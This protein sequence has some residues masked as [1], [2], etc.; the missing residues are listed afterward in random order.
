LP[1]LE[2]LCL[3]RVRASPTWIQQHLQVARSPRLRELC[4]VELWGPHPSAPPK[5]DKVVSPDFLGQLDVLQANFS[6]V[7]ADSEFEQVLHPP[8]LVFSSRDTG[9]GPLPRHS[10]CHPAHFRD[11]QDLLDS[12]SLLARQLYLTPPVPS[13]TSPPR[14]LI[15]P[16]NLRRSAETLTHV[17]HHLRAIEDHCAEKGVRIVWDEE[18]HDR[19]FVSPALRRY[20]RELREARALE[21]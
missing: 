3:R 9:P 13:S 16:P 18:V 10:I 20:A 8:V 2:E 19:D 21:R 1:A 6:S 4:V 7:A 15:L 11:P 17:A 14:L 5:L 12:L